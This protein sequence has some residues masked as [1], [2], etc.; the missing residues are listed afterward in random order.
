VRRH[1]HHR[2]LAAE[3]RRQFRELLR[4]VVGSQRCGAPAQGAG[5]AL[6]GAGRPADTEIDPAGVQRVEHAELLGDDQRLVVG[7]HHA[8]RADA[9][10]R[11]DTG[12]VGDQHGG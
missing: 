1:G 3:V 6:V 8:A 11:G 2:S 4:E 5:G 9:D 12:E 10:P 7:Q